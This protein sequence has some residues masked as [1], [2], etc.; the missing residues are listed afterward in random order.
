M[1][2]DITTL[3]ELA[4]INPDGFILGKKTRFSGIGPE[5][6]KK[7][8][9]RARLL[10]TPDAKPYL[11]EPVRLPASKREL[12][13]DVEVDPS[14][15]HLYL[16]GFVVRDQG[17]AE[18]RFVSFIAESPQPESERQAFADAMAF[19]RASPDATVY[20]YSHYERTRYRVL[21]QRY[22]EVASADDIEALFAEIANRRSLQDRPV[23]Y[24]MAYLG[25]IGQDHRQVSRLQLA[26]SQSIRSRF[27]RVV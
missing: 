2:G 3:A 15:D 11:T 13:F 24:R 16:H 6:L 23:V 5:T 7:F 9:T 21:Q 10:K 8:Y 14:R 1:I 18:D 12:H 26:R 4:E 25:Q 20:V 19:F 17:V 27:D 22:P